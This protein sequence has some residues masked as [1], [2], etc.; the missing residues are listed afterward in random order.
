M[1]DVLR[2]IFPDEFLE[3]AHRL[4]RETSGCVALARNGTALAWLGAQFRDGAAGKRYLCLL[5]GVF[6]QSTVEVDAALARVEVGQ[7]RMVEVAEGGKPAL[8]RFHRLQAYPGSTYAEAELLT[9][10]T[11]QIRVHAQHLG[12]PLA[13][14]RKY[15]PRDALK[16]WR[17][18]GLKRMFLHA[19]V[20]ELAT[21]D[22]GQM[23]FSAPLP[24]ELSAVL[25]TLE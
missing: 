6:P 8:T 1:I 22:G 20:L 2:S 12:M 3:L 16:R 19:H 24:P 4:D 21:T 9:G 10:R 23:E 17:K 7:R 5:D 11:H 18:R 25:S 14:D 13:G 15:A